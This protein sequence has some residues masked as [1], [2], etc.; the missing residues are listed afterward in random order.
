MDQHGR[1]GRKR[2]LKEIE[3]FRKKNGHSKKKLRGDLTAGD[4]DQ[5]GILELRISEK[6]K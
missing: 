5:S 4:R 2:G 3:V 1:L 6:V